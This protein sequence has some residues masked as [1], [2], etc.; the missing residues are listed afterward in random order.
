MHRG[1]TSFAFLARIIN[2][3]A[4]NTGES[5][6]FFGGQ[7]SLRKPPCALKE[8]DL[9]IGRPEVTE[10]TA[11]VSLEHQIGVLKLIVKVSDE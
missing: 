6:R 10:G 7:V 8:A 5:S 2:Y 4:N 3:L 11:T 1:A 9:M